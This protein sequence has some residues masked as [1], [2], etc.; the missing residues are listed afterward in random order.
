MK[1]A[2]VVLEMQRRGMPQVLVHTGQHYDSTMSEVFL[3]ELGMPAPD[4]SLGVGSGSHAEQTAKIMTSFE[5]V[6]L[7]N[8]FDLVTVGGDVNSTIACALVASKLGIPIAHIEAGLRS[9][10]RGMP[11]EINRVLTDHLSELLFTTEKSANLNLRREGI[12]TRLI[13]FVG[14]CMVDTLLKHR[15]TAISRVPWQKFN[16]KPGSYAL[17]TLHRPSNVD[18]SKNLSNLIM[19]INEISQKIPVIFPAHPRTRERLAIFGISTDATVIISDPLPYLAFLG[20]MAKARMVLTDSGGIQEETTI[21][22]VPCLTLRPNTERPVTTTLGT[23]RVVG[24]AHATILQ[25][26]DE[27]LGWKW[28]STRKKPPLWDGAAAARIVDIIEEWSACRK[29]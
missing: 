14:N 6:C 20:I 4:I 5:K 23:N 28:V 27:I 29:L 16:L 8:K 11:E 15:D 10:D 12:A 21:L 22:N 25:A 19:V 9:F 26:V 13:H 3:K 2:P 18:D 24:T 17:L 7:G 1:M